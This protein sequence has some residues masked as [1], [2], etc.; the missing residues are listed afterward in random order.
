VEA[1]PVG[2]PQPVVP[3]T[4]PMPMTGPP[5]LTLDQLCA[6]PGLLESEIERIEGEITGKQAQLALLKVAFDN[7]KP[8]KKRSKK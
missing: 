6:D 2:E 8:K 4:S 3:V 5:A 7:L 1:Q